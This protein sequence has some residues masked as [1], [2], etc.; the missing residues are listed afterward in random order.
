MQDAWRF[1]D[2]TA[3]RAIY[4]DASFTTDN[5]RETTSSHCAYIYE[6]TIEVGRLEI[7]YLGEI[8]EETSEIFI[9]E[10]RDLLEAL[11]TMIGSYLDRRIAEVSLA[12]SERNYR[13]IIEDQ[14]EF[15]T[16]WH[17]D[18]IRTFVN[19][20]FCTY[21]GMQ[22]DEVIG[23]SF[24][25]LIHPDDLQGV[26]DKISKIT[27]EN[28]VSTTTHRVI[29][30]DCTIG[31]N[32]WT[33]RGLFDDDGNLV[34]YQSTGRDVTL[35]KE[36]EVALQESEERYRLLFENLADGVAIVALD[37]RI[38]MINN[39]L[40]KIFG[41]EEDEVKGHSITEFLH[42]DVEE[43][44][45]SRFNEGLKEGRIEPVAIETEGVRKDGSS[46]HFSV[47]NTLLIDDG[48]PVAYQAVIRDISREKEAEKAILEER[49]RA[50][51]YLDV[52][53]AMMVV[54][55][56]NGD[57]SLINRKGC[58]ILGHN[59]EEIVGKNWF[60]NFIPES[61]REKT[62]QI[63]SQL[64]EGNNGEFAQ[65][66]NAIITS[67][68]KERFIEWRN[69]VIR[70]EKGTPLGTISSGVDI[71]ERQKAEDALLAEKEF[72][73][74]AINE[75]IDTFFVFDPFTGKAL[76][77][78]QAFT[79]ISGYSNEEIA[80]LKTP[81]SYYS[82]EDLEKASDIIQNVFTEG[83]ATTEIEL[84]TK[85]GERIPFEY[86]VTAAKD[87]DGEVQFLVSIGRNITERQIADDTLKSAAATANLYLDIMGHDIRNHLM[88]IVMGTEIMQNY[89]LSPDLLEVYELIYESVM[90]SQ[91]LINQ[92]HATRELL[93]APLVE[94][95]FNS[96][97]EH[98]I[99]ESKIKHASVEFYSDI[100]L[101]DVVVQADEYLNVMIL[102]LIDNAIIHNSSEEPQVWVSLFSDENG[103][104]L[105]VC[106][107]G[108]GIPDNRKES[109][110]DPE[111]RFGGVG[112]HQAKKIAEKYGGRISVQDRVE[113]ESSQG[114]CFKVWLP[115]LDRT[116]GGMSK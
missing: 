28:P 61:V 82:K 45:L 14:T 27:F 59:Q 21:L 50:Q 53:G 79:E 89:E 81:D 10:E 75:Q 26:K 31:W 25:T 23:T 95:S 46:F 8:A 44:I 11:A 29:L 2:D 84:I 16:R 3:V 43:D 6:N 92:V 47:N 106:D 24:Y 35:R 111:R 54:L 114:A 9:Q 18:G 33:D 87:K 70:D 55:D 56:S 65:N 113:G 19:D 69:S 13:R 49:D 73:E 51:L 83:K 52:A 99:S 104:T 90:K 57:V 64:M 115:N 85:S 62:Y 116:N 86:V 68:G 102:N 41:Y 108:P 96:I 93:T 101:A 39:R 36:A 94:Q 60:F 12:E 109:L 15:I 67:D 88:A 78:N 32:E 66:V 58:E 91:R 37:G 20:S 40:L 42:P 1:P 110:F 22:R 100:K 48:N 112:V 74:T 80:E 38:S 71:T 72:A 97:V 4:Q 5:F 30:P 105:S 63:Y 7:F 17:S 98:C 76:R 77:W 107:N 103:Y 34:E